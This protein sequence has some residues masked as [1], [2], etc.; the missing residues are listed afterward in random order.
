MRRWERRKKNVDFFCSSF[1]T[2]SS[3]LV[4]GQADG[5][6]LLVV[7]GL[8]LEVG[9]R[10]ADE[11]G[12]FLSWWGKKSVGG[13]EG[14]REFSVRGLVSP[15]RKKRLCEKKKKKKESPSF[16]FCEPSSPV[17]IARLESPFQHQTVHCCV[18]SRCA[19]VSCPKSL[20]LART[21]F[22]FDS[23]Q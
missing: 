2:Y 19:R 18:A 23:D 22:E 1:Q 14:S 4:L 9:R 5:L 10:G 12:L 3:Y 11:R 13:K 15:R 17:L 20:H 6:E 7:D 16:F 8:G 21:A